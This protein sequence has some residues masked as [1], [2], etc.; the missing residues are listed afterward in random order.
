MKISKS[1]YILSILGL[2]FSSAINAQ[3]SQK[4][5]S[6]VAHDKLLKSQNNYQEVITQ[7]EQVV[8]DIIVRK[9]LKRTTEEIYTIPVVVHVVHTGEAIG[10]EHNISDAQVVSGIE[11]LNMAF[12][13]KHGQSV[14]VKIEFALAKIDPNCNPTDGINRVDGSSIGGYSADGVFLGSVG[15]DEKLIK[16]LS[17]WPNTDYYNIWLVTEFDNNEGGNGTQGFAYFPGASANVDGAIILN[18]AWGDQG[19]AKSWNNEGETGVH[20]IGHALN[21]WHTFEG[22]SEG[23]S[24]PSDG[25]GR[26]LGDCCDDTPI[27]IRSSQ[28]PEGE[29]NS[30]TGLVNGDFIHNY[31]DYSNQECGYLFTSDQKDRMRAALEGPRA[32]LLSSRALDST[33][34]FSAPKAASCTPTTG[35][36]GMDKNFAGILNVQFGDINYSSGYPKTDGG[37]LDVTSNCLNSINLEEGGSY[38]LS[39]TV[40]VNTNAVKA[41]ID[42]DNDGIFSETTELVFDKS[43]ASGSTGVETVAIPSSAIK[44]TYLRMRVM[45]DLGSVTDACY[46]P[47]R[48]QAEDYA[49]VIKS[50]TS[51]RRVQ[52]KNSFVSVTPNPFKTE[53]RI[54]NLSSEEGSYRIIDVAGQTVRTGSFQSSNNEYSINTVSLKAGSYFIIIQN[55]PNTIS[56]KLIK[57]RE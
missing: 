30:C 21:L 14:D 47:S 13:N 28:C 33:I 25:C 56:M 12:R 42:Y 1:L 32:S 34:S 57:L 55:G 49:V 4:C 23:D 8:K 43:I 22:D 37:Y 5:G 51:N 41:W 19:T 27:H 44:D 45:N 46:N 36:T 35:S 9:K 6:S 11:Q 54:T 53:I 20:E 52:N 24:C 40:G 50:T 17:I 16:A 3:E 7:N 38:D 39:V 26:D 10:D 15:A 2:T 48:G 18:S 31:M 29:T